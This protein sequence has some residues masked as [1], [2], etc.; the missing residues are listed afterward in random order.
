M[1]GLKLGFHS[2]KS[3]LSAEEIQEIINW[4]RTKNDWNWD[5]LIAHVDVNDDVVYQSKQ[6][7]YDLLAAASVTWKRSQ[8]IVLFVDEYW[9]GRCLCG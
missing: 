7:D 1:E 3:H 2:R 6:S 5:E 8:L 4:L 9:L